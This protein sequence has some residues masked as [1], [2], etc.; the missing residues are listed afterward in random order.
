MRTGSGIPHDFDAYARD[1]W[2]QLLVTARLLT[3]DLPAARELALST[4]AR[5][6]ARWGRVP[7]NDVDFHVRRRLVRTWLL[8]RRWPGRRRRAARQQTVLVLR[9]WEAVP[10]KQIAQL[11]GTSAGAVRHLDRRG[12]KAVGVDARRL[13]EVYAAWAGEVP[14][15][16]FPREAV[17][18]RG[19]ALRRRRTA[20]LA[21][22][23][24]AVLAL[25]AYLAV[26][27]GGGTGA[28]AS[29]GTAAGRTPGTVR[30][31]A[32]GERVDAAPGVQLW[33]TA[34]GSHWSTPR[35]NDVFS[36]VANDRHGEPGV[37]SQQAE[38]VRGRYLLS[39]VYYGVHGD[40]GG[41]ELDTGHSRI[42]AKVLT[43]AGSPGWGVWYASVPVSGRDAK[44]ILAGS[45]ERGAGGDTGGV[46]VYDSAG[47]VLARL[48]F[49]GW[50]A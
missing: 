8:R 34:D 11:L 27:L 23:C 26:G 18:T 1:R 10:D 36:G 48:R 44:A 33:L 50:R 43:L 6:Y 20:V 21:A 46:K 45:T 14:D 25:P 30:I 38:P 29:S 41:V 4:L 42:A 22:G 7:R 16:P 37:S 15:S 3:G 19:R 31:V 40:P 9:H 39:G 49:G 47:A 24:A 13:R 32:P 35:E 17:R 12:M 2:P 5:V 28:E